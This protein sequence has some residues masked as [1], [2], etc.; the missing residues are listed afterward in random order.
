MT[1]GSEMEDACVHAEAFVPRPSSLVLRLWSNASVF[2]LGRPAASLIVDD[3]QQDPQVEDSDDHEAHQNCGTCPPTPQSSVCRWMMKMRDKLIVH[4][5]Q[6]TLSV[7]GR[8]GGGVDPRWRRT[9]RSV[10][11]TLVLLDSI[12]CSTNQLLEAPDDT[13]SAPSTHQSPQYPPRQ[14]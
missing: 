14:V 5:Q 11:D 4:E 8:H 6:L 2:F 3:R 7:P 12:R 10:K 1:L 13:T 9:G